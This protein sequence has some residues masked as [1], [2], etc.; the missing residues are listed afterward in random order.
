MDV[1]NVYSKVYYWRWD[2]IYCIKDDNIKKSCIFFIEKF[3]NIRFHMN[4]QNKAYISYIL[5]T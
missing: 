2:C 5:F 4:N 3:L 1:M